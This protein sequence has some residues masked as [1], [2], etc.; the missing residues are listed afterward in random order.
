MRSKKNFGIVYTISRSVR[1]ARL[2]LRR[3]CKTVKASKI[4][5]LIRFAKGVERDFEEITAFF[6]LRLILGLIESFLKPNW[7]THS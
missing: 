4:E 2:R 6:E 5:A 1:S 7:Q 3:W